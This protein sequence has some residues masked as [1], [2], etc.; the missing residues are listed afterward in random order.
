MY[1][2]KNYNQTIYWS[3]FYIF[4]SSMNLIKQMMHP[5]TYCFAMYIN[6]YFVNDMEWYNIDGKMILK[7]IIMAYMHLIPNKIESNLISCI[8]C[9][10]SQGFQ[11]TCI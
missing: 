9:V 4:Y 10:K 2:Q 7:I 8:Y 3:V 6:T 5:N 1:S 11:Q